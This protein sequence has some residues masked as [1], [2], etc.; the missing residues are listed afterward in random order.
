M[1][2][3][4]RT[5]EPSEIV[6]TIGCVFVG[7]LCQKVQGFLHI[8]KEIFYKRVRNHRSRLKNHLIVVMFLWNATRIDYFLPSNSGFLTLV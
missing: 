8:L 6:Y 5:L 4:Q 1:V 2:E 7:N 3:P